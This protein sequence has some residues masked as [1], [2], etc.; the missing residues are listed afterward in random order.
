MVKSNVTK[1][2]SLPVI[3]AIQKQW[4]SKD[5]LVAAAVSKANGGA[6]PWPLKNRPSLACYNEGAKS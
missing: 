4:P 1:S 2:T 6:G 3:R 5:E